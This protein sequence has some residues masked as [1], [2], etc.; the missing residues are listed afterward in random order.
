MNARTFLLRAALLAGALG[1]MS[2]SAMAQRDVR[3]WQ[4]DLHDWVDRCRSWGNGDWDDHYRVCDTQ[5]QSMRASGREI[6]VDAGQNGGITVAAWDG[7]S[8]LIGAKVQ[9]SAPSEAEAKEIASQVHIVRDGSR[10]HAEGPAR[11][12]R[13]SWSVSF[14]LLVPRRSDLS[15]EANNGGIHVADVQ[16]RMELSTVNGGL[17]LD[18]VGGDVHGHTT[19]GGLDIRLSGQRWAGDGLDVSTTNGGVRL[20]VPRDYSAQLETGTVNGGMNIDFPITVQGR[21]GRRLS[22]Q[23]GSGGPTIRATTTNGGVSIRRG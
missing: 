23:L 20:H 14:E 18:G 13:T 8:V 15:L 9:A 21:I 7:D 11:R 1:T 10:I 17:S 16:G 2:S 12:S 3:E 4:Q 19:N 5:Q 6:A 22:T